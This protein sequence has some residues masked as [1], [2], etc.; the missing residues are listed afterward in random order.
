MLLADL[1]KGNR[2][3]MPDVARIQVIMC[4]KVYT[5]IISQHC[6]TLGLCMVISM[7]NGTVKKSK[8]SYNAHI[9][10]TEYICRMTN[11][12]K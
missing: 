11:Q 7:V 8:V 10:C 12:A 4:F 2:S 6:R 5:V 9:T 3:I 1:T